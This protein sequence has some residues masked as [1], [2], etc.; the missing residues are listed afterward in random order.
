[1]PEP[2]MPPYVVNLMI[3]LSLILAAVGVQLI[4]VFRTGARIKRLEK[5]LG[6]PTKTKVPVENE[7]GHAETSEGGAF[8]A[9]LVADP[10]QR[11]LSKAEQFANFRKWRQDKGLNW[12]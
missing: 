10:Q 9:F 4:V 2:E 6:S 8:E 5:R 3:F 1:M 7:S 11:M 12:G